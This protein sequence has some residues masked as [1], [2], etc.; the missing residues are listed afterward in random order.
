[1][2]EVPELE[3]RILHRR[4]CAW[5]EAHG[6]VADAIKHALAAQDVAAAARLIRDSFEAMATVGEFTTLLGWLNTLP[7]QLVRSDSDLSCHKGWVLY[8]RGQIDSAEGYAAAAAAQQRPDASPLQ[9]GM[10]LAFQAFL[11][12]N[13]GEPG[14]AVQLAQ[15]ALTLLG[16]SESFFRTTALSHLGQAL[17]LTGDRQLA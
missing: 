12:I 7:E 11:A 10:L 15:S 6:F 4:A 13:R 8:L 14:R 16:G 1:R 2:A 9:R 3:Q 5:Y 17:R